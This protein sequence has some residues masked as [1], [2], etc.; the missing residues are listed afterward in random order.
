M[1]FHEDE[2]EM[3]ITRC[4]GR[5][6]LFWYL[7]EKETGKVHGTEEETREAIWGASSAL[8]EHILDALAN[9]EDPPSATVQKYVLGQCRKWNLVW[10]GRHRVAPLEPDEIEFLLGFPKDHTR[11][12]NSTERY[13]SLGNSFQVHTVAYHLSVLREMFPNG[14]NVL[15]LFSEIGGAKI[16]LHKLGIRMKTMVSVESITSDW[17]ESTIKEIGGLDLVIGGS[18]CNN[19]TGSNRYHRGG[20]EGEHSSL[21]Y[22]YSR[23]L[24]CVKYSSQSVMQRV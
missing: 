11:G 22:H 5:F 24:D 19:F 15:S 14:M 16:A 21:F 8:I 18:P 1:G 3:A 10:V 7:C 9:S 2:D 6:G 12:I 20:L 23:I 13:R 4:R 17:L